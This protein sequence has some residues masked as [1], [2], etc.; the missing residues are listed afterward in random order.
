[1]FTYWG[2][3]FGKGKAH[4]NSSVYIVMV[5]IMVGGLWGVDRTMH[6]AY[7]MCSMFRMGHF[8]IC[9]ILCI[10]MVGIL[11][12]RGQA[13]PRFW[14]KLWWK[15]LVQKQACSRGLACTLCTCGLMQR[16]VHARRGK[17]GLSGTRVAS[18]GAQARLQARLR[19]VACKGTRV[20]SVG[21]WPIQITAASMSGPPLGNMPFKNPPPFNPPSPPSRKLPEFSF[22]EARVFLCCEARTFD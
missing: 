2:F 3:V 5:G 8:N 14:R 15:S 17:S 10:C 7:L 9:M 19:V 12:H 20:A 16:S 4:S 22:R 21:T 6:F 1:M 18:V 11:D 13:G